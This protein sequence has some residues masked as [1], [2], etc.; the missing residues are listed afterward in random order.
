MRL[1]DDAKSAWRWFSMRCMGAALALQGA[2]EVL[3]DDMKS[4]IPP[5]LVTYAALGLL[6]LGMAGRVVKQEKP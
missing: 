5:K 6:A 2:W 3:P 1:V 4:G